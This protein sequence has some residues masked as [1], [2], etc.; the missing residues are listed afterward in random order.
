MNLKIK[1]V[2]KRRRNKERA[3]ELDTKLMDFANQRKPDPALPV[4]GM[5]RKM[6]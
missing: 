2:S 3:Q 1:K 5:L 6:Q 4:L